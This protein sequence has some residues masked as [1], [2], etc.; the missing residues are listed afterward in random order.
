MSEPGT[1]SRLKGSLEELEDSRSDEKKGEECT[2][3][4]R[5]VK[6]DADVEPEKDFKIFDALCTLNPSII[7]LK[8]GKPK[9]DAH[10]DKGR[11]SRRQSIIMIQRIKDQKPV[12]GLVSTGFLRYIEGNSG[13]TGEDSWVQHKLVLY[14]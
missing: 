12:S 4:Q 3:E 10:T 5:E 2:K 8:V 13:R 1:V 9:E 14:Q 11:E 6:E 7:E